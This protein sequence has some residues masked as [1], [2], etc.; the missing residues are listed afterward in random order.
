MNA[1]LVDVGAAL[2]AS[3]PG[4][5]RRA[6]PSAELTTYRCGGPLAVFVRAEREHDL[7]LVADVIGPTDVPVLVIGRGSN[8]L[9]A[10]AGFPGVAISL[11]GELERLDIDA[12]AASVHA[13]GG[14]PPNA[15]S[16]VA[17]APDR[18]TGVMRMPAA[19]T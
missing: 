11:G 6:V 16:M 5:V 4:Q 12:G 15:T 18:A 1:T 9:V 2:D 3:L 10:D 8:L 14:V 7:Q 19:S 13:G 17:L